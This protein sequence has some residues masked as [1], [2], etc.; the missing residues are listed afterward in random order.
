MPTDYRRLPPTQVAWSGLARR[1]PLAAALV[2]T[3]A[4]LFGVLTWAV[5]G[6]MSGTGLDLRVLDWMI[7]HR[8]EP[9]TG[10]ARVITDL[11]GTVAMA[12]LAVLTGCWFLSQRNLPV[13]ALVGVTSLG[14]WALIWVIKRVIG[15][16]RPPM[17]SRLVTELSLSYPSGHSLGSTAVVGIVAIVLIPRLR[18]H[19]L[20]VAA[21][22]VAIAFPITV[23]LSRIYLGVHWATDVL[24]GWTIGLLWLTVC[25]TLFA[26][27]H[28]VRELPATAEPD[29]ELR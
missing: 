25:V 3:A 18:N 6:D 22:A 9:L 29:A 16:H 10:I 20:R 26:R 15:R 8:G 4:A 1:V 14:A 7:D 5:H 11:G 2:V 23:G 21:V 13:A 27:L 17:E 28:P 12:I 24:A 19:W